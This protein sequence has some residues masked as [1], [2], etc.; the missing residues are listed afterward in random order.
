MVSL[1][2]KWN[3][4]HPLFLEILISWADGY[5]LILSY[6]SFIFV[7]GCFVFFVDDSVFPRWTGY[8]FRFILRVLLLFVCF[9]ILANWKTFI[10]CKTR[11][12]AISL[13]H[14]TAF[15]QAYSALFQH[16]DFLRWYLKFICTL[17]AVPYASWY[18]SGNYN[19]IFFV[20]YLC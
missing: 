15:G 19:F 14:I 2:S 10:L 3:Q 18:V 4:T 12:C 5:S 11:C 7:T 6:G 1:K 9:C 17:S 8:V 20:P 13:R 16:S